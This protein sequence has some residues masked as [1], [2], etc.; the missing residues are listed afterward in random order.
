V[1]ADAAAIKG[2][3]VRHSTA[4]MCVAMAIAPALARPALNSQ[5]WSGGQTGNLSW[6]LKSLAANLQVRGVE[7]DLANAESGN[8]LSGTGAGA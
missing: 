3:R 1:T 4:G 5:T 2:M 6:R 7:Y 8:S